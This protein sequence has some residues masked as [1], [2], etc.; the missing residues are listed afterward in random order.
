MSRLKGVERELAGAKS[1]RSGLITACA[2]AQSASSEVA[3]IERPNV[4]RRLEIDMLSQKESEC[5]RLCNECAAACLQC[6]SACL[7]EPEVTAM[8]RCI[9]L[10]MECA[11]LCQLAAAAMA[12]GDAH[13]KAVC[14]ICADV[15]QSCGDECAKHA[16]DHCKKCA[17]AC[18]KCAESLHSMAH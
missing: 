4:R 17:D 10:D 6:A 13:K 14:S 9:A 11:D 12:R 15:C 1:T 3:M 2:A 16:M 7:K 18:K 8:A 5:L